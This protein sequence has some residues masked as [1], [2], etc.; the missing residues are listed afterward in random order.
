VEDERLEVLKMEV[1]GRIGT[2]EIWSDMFEAGNWGRRVEEKWLRSCGEVNWSLIKAEVL[3]GWSLKQTRWIWSR[4]SV[5][6]DLAETDLEV[7]AQALPE[8][9]QKSWL[10]S[11]NQQK[12][13][14]KEDDSSLRV[15]W[16]LSSSHSSPQAIT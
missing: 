12:S 14:L 8:I 1:N 5:S 6:I 2:K 3:E 7:K 15:L 16:T 13:R 11:S 4:K 10:S 9:K